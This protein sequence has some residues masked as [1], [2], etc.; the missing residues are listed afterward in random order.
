MIEKID[1]THDYG[2]PDTHLPQY[3]RNIKVCPHVTEDALHKL[4][5][6]IY[7]S[8]LK[9][10]ILNKEATDPEPLESME[11]LLVSILEELTFI[12]SLGAECFVC[13]QEEVCTN[14]HNIGKDVFM[15]GFEYGSDEYNGDDEEDHY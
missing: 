11:K 12:N 13:T 3:M 4:F 9:F 6:D 15:E 10:Y 8:Y 1:F 7:A 2:L 14:Q 5:D